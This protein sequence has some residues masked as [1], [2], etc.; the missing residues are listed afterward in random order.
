MTNA[1]TKEQNISELES[2]V[3][4]IKVRI[5]ELRGMPNSRRSASGLMIQEYWVIDEWEK[6]DAEL[7]RLLAEIELLKN[8]EGEKLFFICYEAKS[9]HV[10]PCITRNGIVVSGGLLDNYF[11]GR[12][13]S[14]HA[15]YVQG[16]H[17][18]V[19]TEI[20]F[21]DVVLNGNE[22]NFRIKFNGHEFDFR[23]KFKFPVNDT[24]YFYMQF[25]EK[26][27]TPVN[28]DRGASEKQRCLITYG[29]AYLFQ[30][31]EEVKRHIHIRN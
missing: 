26:S 4:S 19:L 7:G 17:G 20:N 2:K 22:I 8:T 10:V 1:N 5:N 18:K 15:S 9:Y 12:V 25:F 14:E 6:K 28:S 30:Q 13:A 29:A 16:R 21:E 11:T 3:N 27:I 31:S 23:S 24:K